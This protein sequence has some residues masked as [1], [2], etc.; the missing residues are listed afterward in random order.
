MTEV[1]NSTSKLNAI[2]DYDN[3]IL[4]LKNDIEKLKEF[5][6]A[7]L[8]EKLKETKSNLNLII[9]WTGIIFS[10]FTIILALAGILGIYELWRIRKISSE[11]KSELDLLKLQKADVFSEMSVIAKFEAGRQA[12]YY[13]NLLE[14]RR[15]F[16]ELLELNNTD[17]RAYYYIGNSFRLEN[18]FNNAIDSFNKI[19]E[20]DPKNSEGYYGLAM[21]FF[22]NKNE[23]EAIDNFKLALEFNPKHDKA[24]NRLGT[25][26]RMTTLIKDPN[27][28]LNKALECYSKAEKIS[29][30]AYT[31]FNK[32]IIFFAM[33]NNEKAKKIFTE[34]EYHCFE[35]IKKSQKL[36][37]AYHYLAVIEGLRGNIFESKSLLIKAVNNNDS[38]EFRIEMKQDLDF[39]SFFAPKNSNVAE[40][41]KNLDSI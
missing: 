2:S 36:H 31:S 30:T 9:N 1:Q 10:A 14:A 16:Y 38:S 32:G 41:I 40:M 5:N 37:W 15:I 34:A 17:S 3:L 27:E 6:N 13:G 21:T 24:L 8:K 4:K 28:R 33:S 39:L 22:K 20:I 29:R 25:L 26:Y 19:L 35:M 18:E 11:M 12:Y 23:S 7:Q